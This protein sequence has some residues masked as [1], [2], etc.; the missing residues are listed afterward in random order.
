MH[1]AGTGVAVD[2]V[3]PDSIG[4]HGHDHGHKHRI[5]EMDRSHIMEVS[6][7]WGLFLIGI[8]FSV[9]VLWCLIKCIDITDR[10]RMDR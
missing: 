10:D 8:P 1:E 4:V 7:M 6:P 2:E 3:V 5:T 9:V